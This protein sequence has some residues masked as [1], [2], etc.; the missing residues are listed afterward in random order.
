MLESDTT[1]TI[2]ADTLEGTEAT[3]LE[4]GHSFHVACVLQWFRYEHKTCPNCRSARTQH[5]WTHRT[6]LQ[7]VADLRKRR[8]KLPARV[9]K[10]LLRCDDARKQTAQVKQELKALRRE[11]KDLFRQERLL[12]RKSYTCARRH[13]QLVSQLSLVSAPGVPLLVYQGYDSGDEQE[14][15][16]DFE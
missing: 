3:T 10:Q 1:C 14:D 13:R 9:Q 15:D 4:C 6:P 8:S 12:R 7:R 16:D 2:C 11:H 5:V